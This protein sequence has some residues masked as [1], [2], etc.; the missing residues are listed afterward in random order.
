M[1]GLKTFHI[2]LKK[3]NYNSEMKYILFIQN[4]EWWA[5]ACVHFVTGK[6]FCN[7][8][9]KMLEKNKNESNESSLPWYSNLLTLMFTKENAFELHFKIK[10]IHILLDMRWIEMENVLETESRRQKP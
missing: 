6:I 10:C 3:Q 9:R 7:W 1:S 2:Y 5:Y 8:T 4:D